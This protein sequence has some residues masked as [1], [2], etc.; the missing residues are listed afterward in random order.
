MIA[1]NFERLPNSF[2]SQEVRTAALL[3][4]IDKLVELGAAYVVL[5]GGAGTLAELGIV[6]NLALLGALQDKPLIVV[7]QG[8]ERVLQ[9]DGRRAAH[10]RGRPQMAALRARRRR[11]RFEHC[12]DV[13][14]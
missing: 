10:D 2:L 4:R 6:W 9:A 3:E 5:P 7:G 8:W 12:A 1:R 14:T 13:L 11:R